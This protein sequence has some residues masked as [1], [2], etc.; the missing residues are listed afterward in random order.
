MYAHI[1]SA[2]LDAQSERGISNSSAGKINVNSVKKLTTCAD[3]L[4]DNHV[5]ISEHGK[6]CY[7]KTSAQ[8]SQK[9]G[10]P[11]SRDLQ[12]HIL[13]ISCLII[14]TYTV[15]RILFSTRGVRTAN[16]MM[17]GQVQKHACAA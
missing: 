14:E 12:K 1:H 5:V 6:S 7:W 9:M 2:E 17:Q 3:H 8:S 10:S 4:L 15:G 13:L 11:Q 16:H